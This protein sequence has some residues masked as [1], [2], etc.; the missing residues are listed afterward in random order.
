MNDEPIKKLR[1]INVNKSV[2]QKC[3]LL[4]LEVLGSPKKYAHRFLSIKYFGMCALR[5]NAKY[6]V[7]W[8]LRVARYLNK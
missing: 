6:F 4:E 3:R 8:L 5:V 1:T 2:N 7:F